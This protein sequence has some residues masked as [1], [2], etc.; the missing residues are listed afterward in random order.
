MGVPISDCIVVEDVP[1]GIQS[2]KSAGARVI[3]FETMSPREQLAAAGPDWIVRDC[4]DIKVTV[5]GDELKVELAAP[6]VVA[7]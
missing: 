3:A 1:A 2:G 6:M 7:V 5:A 4:R